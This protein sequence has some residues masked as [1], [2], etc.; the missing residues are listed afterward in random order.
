MSRSRRRNFNNNNI[1]PFIMILSGLLLI[2]FW[3]PLWVWLV[4]LGVFLIVFGTKMYY[5]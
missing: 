4:V 3:L 2:V 1:F 5:R